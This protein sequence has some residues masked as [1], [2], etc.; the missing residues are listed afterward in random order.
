MTKFTLANGMDFNSDNVISKGLTLEYPYIKNE[1]DKDLE[2]DKYNIDDYIFFKKNVIEND[3]T[4]HVDLKLF[5]K[6]YDEK[7]SYYFSADFL[8]IL[9]QNN[10]SFKDFI[11]FI[12]N[13][14]LPE[15][16]KT[17]L[18]TIFQYDNIKDNFLENLLKSYVKKINRLFPKNIYLMDF[19]YITLLRGRVIK[20]LES[21]ITF[22]FI[23]YKFN[24]KETHENMK[25]QLIHFLDKYEIDYSIKEY[26]K[27]YYINLSCEPLLEYFEYFKLNIEQEL[28][29]YEIDL[30]N[31]FIKN[32]LEN[33]NNNY[34]CNNNFS[35][36]LIKYSFSN[37]M[38]LYRTQIK[39][40]EYP[41]SLSSYNMSEQDK[42][43]IPD[44][45]DLNDGYII[46]II[47]KE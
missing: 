27:Y 10:L 17:T 43:L 34:Y 47:T 22:K 45:I 8:K 9:D 30:V 5:S 19:I 38:P 25:T 39:H 3:I 11:F 40:S 2:A 29:T 41:Y 1:L 28:K 6:T 12:N 24:K 42:S 31:Y 7:Y 13:K 16:T 46:K 18:E 4:T 37:G 35:S 36:S 15:N 33:S 20:L 14:D 44:I 21:N 32:L 23:S 26:D